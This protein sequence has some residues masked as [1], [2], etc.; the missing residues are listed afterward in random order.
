[1][2][3]CHAL[4]LMALAQFPAATSGS[5]IAEVISPLRRALNTADQSRSCTTTRFRCSSLRLNS[6]T[7]TASALG[8]PALPQQKDGLPAIMVEHEQANG[9]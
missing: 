2:L 5:F 3:Q 8:G 1:M 4:A 6:V 7:A 9:G